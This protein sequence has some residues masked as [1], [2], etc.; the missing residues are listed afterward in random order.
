[1]PKYNSRRPVRN[2]KDGV[3]IV[4]EGAPGGM[5]KIRDPLGHGLAVPYKDS[6]GNSVLRAP[7]GRVFIS[8]P[9]K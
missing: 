4:A 1:M 9:F 6:K 7:D 8:K 5:R 2:V 3:S